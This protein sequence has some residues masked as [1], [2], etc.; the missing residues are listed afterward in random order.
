M[1]IER[2]AA[3]KKRDNRMAKRRRNSTAWAGEVVVRRV[4]DE[5]APEP[6]PM[7]VERA[8]RTA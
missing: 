4:G 7:P 3:R 8:H 5:P 2:S 6:P 1:G